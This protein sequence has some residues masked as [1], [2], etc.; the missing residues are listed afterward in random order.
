MQRGNFKMQNYN[1]QR[2]RVRGSFPH[3]EMKQGFE[4]WVKNLRSIEPAPEDPANP[5]RNV[6]QIQKQK[7]ELLVHKPGAQEQQ[8]DIEG[9]SQDD[10]GNGG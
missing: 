3:E 8:P 1:P 10:G 5:S 6:D 2:K 9:H 7:K 4:R